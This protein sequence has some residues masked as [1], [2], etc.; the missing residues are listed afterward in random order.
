MHLRRCGNRY[1]FIGGLYV[2]APR[3]KHRL[4]ITKPSLKIMRTR[5]EWGIRKLDLLFPLRRGNAG[6]TDSRLNSTGGAI[7]GD[8]THRERVHMATPVVEHPSGTFTMCIRGDSLRVSRFP[9]FDG[10]ML[11]TV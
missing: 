4:F 3:L 5:L 8:T 6:W 10:D 2:V 9:E 1:P 11:E 7:P